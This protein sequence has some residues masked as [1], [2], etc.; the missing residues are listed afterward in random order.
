MTDP[1]PSPGPELILELLERRGNRVLSIRDIHRRL[2]KGPNEDLS[3]EAVEQMVADLEREGRIVAIRGRKYSL[4]E[5]TPF[6]NGRFRARSDGTGLV[7]PSSR[8]GVAVFVDRKSQR[9]AMDGDVVLVRVERD[10]SPKRL[11]GRELE[12][13][14]ITRILQRAHETVVGRFHQG[15]PSWVRPFDQKL[16]SDILISEES[17]G[18]ARDGEMVD[19]EIEVYADR[20]Q[21][22]RGRIIET[23]GFIWEPGV[24]IEVVIRKYKLPHQFPQEV[25]DDAEKISLEIDPAEISRRRDLRDREIVT[26]DGEHARDFDDAVE[27]RKLPNGNWELGVHIA[28]VSY[29]VRE[30]SAL[31]REAYERATSVYFPGRV[32]PMLPERLS[33]GICSLNPQ[34][35]R[36]TVSALMEIDDRGRFVNR[37]FFRSVIR[38]RERMTY[39]DVNQILAEPTPELRERYSGLLG[40]FDRME[41]LYRILR[42][43]RSS[44]GSLDFDLPQHEVLL[45]EEGEIEAIQSLARNDAHRLIEEFMLAANESV[46][47]HLFFA[48]QPALY[49]NHAAPDLDKLEDMKSLLQEFGYKL[50]G[51]LDEIRPAD[52]Q[53]VLRKIEGTPEEQ[54]L[55]ELILRSMKRAVYSPECQGHFALAFEQYTHFTSPIRRY[56]D[57]IVHRRLTELAARGA[58]HAEEREST[59]SAHV[60]AATHSS[61]RE[62]RAEAA[63]REVMEW[64]KVIFMLDKVGE[65]FNGRVTGVAPFGLFIQLEEHFVQGLVPIASIGGDYWQ[66]LDREHRLKGDRSQREFRL[67]DPVVVE[68]VQVDEDRRQIELRLKEAAGARVDQRHSRRG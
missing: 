13:G 10:A 8:E 54:F 31:D 47:Q 63:E 21:R 17:I 57:L 46:A 65:T 16:D 44:R 11:G 26:I 4:I 9:G 1:S 55:S 18:G 42:T 53:R 39:T 59:E 56:P 35:D 37:E 24:D 66:Y 29:Y 43:R 20:E 64:K 15:N 67:G 12:R 28:D 30:G 48:S 68:V 23:L 51:N 50:K 38:T 22:A 61:E 41:Q 45:T 34:V 27:V 32:V 19:V 7:V 60:A 40:L 36:L 58:L 33:N 52:L 62:R 5:F 14:T 2:A 49:R 3:A 25:L 6:R